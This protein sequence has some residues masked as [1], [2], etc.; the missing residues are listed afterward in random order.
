MLRSCLTEASCRYGIAAVEAG[1]GTHWMH[2]LGTV[3]QGNEVLHALAGLGASA[4]DTTAT[5]QMY[6]V[7]EDPEPTGRQ[8]GKA[9]AGAALGIADIPM[10]QYQIF[11]KTLTG[12]YCCAWRPRFTGGRFVGLTH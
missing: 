4:D 5:L 2:T 11:I 8:D 6:A 10:G 12:N 3:Q 1:V 9:V 7:V